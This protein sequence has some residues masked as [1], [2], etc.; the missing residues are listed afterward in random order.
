MTYVSIYSSFLCGVS[1]IGL[2]TLTSLIF[3]GLYIPLAILFSK[4]LCLG[5][6][7]VVVASI[8]VFTPNIYTHPTQFRKI[9]TNKATGIW[10]K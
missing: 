10:N 8:A 1:K 2:A 6:Y 3:S 5:F 9:I 7:G 4:T